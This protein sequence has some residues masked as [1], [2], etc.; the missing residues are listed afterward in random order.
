MSAG[1]LGVLHGGTASGA[2]VLG[3]AGCSIAHLVL[4]LK[5]AVKLDGDLHV[6]NGKRAWASIPDGD[7]GAV[8]LVGGS[9]TCDAFFL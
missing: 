4:E 8:V 7:P 1:A 9:V 3:F 5:N 2:R 6:I